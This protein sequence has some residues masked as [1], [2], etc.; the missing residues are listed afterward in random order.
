MQVICYISFLLFQDYCSS[1]KEKLGSITLA[2]LLLKWPVLLEP[3]TCP[4]DVLEEM[5]QKALDEREDMRGKLL[6]QDKA[7]TE[8]NDIQYRALPAVEEQ[9]FKLKKTVEKTSNSVI[10][11]E[12]A[13]DSSKTL[14]KLNDV[15]KK[16]DSSNC[17]E[18]EKMEKKS[19]QS[20]GPDNQGLKQ[21]IH[22]NFYPSLPLAN[23]ALPMN[24]VAGVPYFQSSAQH[25]GHQSLTRTSPYFCKYYLCLCLFTT[26]VI[27]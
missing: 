4:L 16:I 12:Q 11:Q 2:D 6:T 19:E 15:A 21:N 26:I 8:M 10:S 17:K 22:S 27:F 3:P 7:L 14:K 24:S 5:T 18:E 9:Y 1:L 20:V 23:A 13:Q 25:Y